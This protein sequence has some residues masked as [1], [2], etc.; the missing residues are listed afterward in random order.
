M[1]QTHLGYLLAL[2]ILLTATGRGG[3]GTSLYSRLGLGDL[4]PGSNVRS[5]GMGYTGIAFASTTTIN[6]LA[7][8]TWSKI[9]RARIEAGMLYEGYNSS[10]GTKSRYLSRADF[11]GATLALPIYPAKGIVAVLG[12]TPFSTVDY[13]A[14]ST[15]RYITGRDTMNSTITYTGRGGISK[16]QIGGSYCPMP[17]LSVGFSM[18]YLFG[19][20]DYATTV[21]ATES[22]YSASTVTRGNSLNGLTFTFGGL[23]EGIGSGA[24]EPLSLGFTV[25]TG[26]SLATTLQNFYEY[27]DQADTSTE[28]TGTTTVPLTIGLGLSY[29]ASDRWICSADF[30]TQRWG[31]ATVDGRTSSFLRT[32]SDIGIGFERLAARE[33]PGTAFLDR[34]AYRM[35][36]FYRSTYITLNNESIN[37]WGVTVGAGIPITNEA[38]LHVALEYGSRGTTSNALIKDSI[39]RLSASVTLSELW[40]TR[41]EED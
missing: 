32:R 8:A 36:M 39:I 22:D 23:Y 2:L 18:N 11:N 21:A 27:S 26:T 1:Q 5:A 17:N 40:F 35:G 16:G 19:T 14:F 31:D 25:T 20:I 10:D 38:R 34:V 30:T 13:K 33:L 41:Y 7:P 3:N 37:A 6:S 29:R 4:H 24:L 12:F 9:D 15:E 28:T